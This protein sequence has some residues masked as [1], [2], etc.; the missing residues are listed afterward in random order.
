MSGSNIEPG[1]KSPGQVR[2]LSHYLKDYRF[3][4][5]VKAA[6]LAE[7]LNY[8]GSRYLTL[9]SEITPHGRFMSS[10][11]F[12]SLLG[13]IDGKS[14]VE[15]VN[16]LYSVKQQ[17]ESKDDLYP[18]ELNILKAVHKLTIPTRK[19]FEKICHNSLRDSAKKLD[20]LLRVISLL[21]EQDQKTV[22]AF[23]SFLES[24]D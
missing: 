4:Y 2:R 3:R 21:A 14:V 7:N 24:M 23:E 11:N 18:G 10:L 5:G 6:D 17:P 19:K 12:L 13:S 1:L 8:K 22:E 20:A 15:I 16:Y 9:E